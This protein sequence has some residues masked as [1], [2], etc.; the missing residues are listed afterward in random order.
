MLTNFLNEYRKS[1]AQAR[2]RVY[3]DLKASRWPDFLDRELNQQ[4]VL[5]AIK[6]L[7][8]QLYLIR[9]EIVN[10]K[11]CTGNFE[12]IHGIPCYHTL[13]NIKRLNAIVRME[14]FHPHW[15]FERP[16]VNDNK[17][18]QL[19]DPL[20]P[21]AGPTIFAPRKVV[22]RGRKYKD[23]STRRD[24]S[25]F[26]VTIGTAPPRPGRVGGETSRVRIVSSFT[27]RS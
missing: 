21:P 3:Y 10:N 11:L 4:V 23:N 22:T 1:M 6:L 18:L 25:Q 24:P 13:R 26:E 27:A 5:E 7:V 9:D 19:P 12:A 2:D 14:D 15:Y 20:A 8:K 16:V 17:P